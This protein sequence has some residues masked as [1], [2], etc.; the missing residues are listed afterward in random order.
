[1]DLVLELSTQDHQIFLNLYKADYITNLNELSTLIKAFQA[2]KTAIDR[3]GDILRVE[4]ERMN[5]V[6]ELTQK[7]D[8]TDLE[9]GSLSPRG[10]A[11]KLKA[12][13]GEFSQKIVHHSDLNK[14]A[15]KH[16]ECINQGK[17]KVKNIVGYQD[18]LLRAHTQMKDNQCK[19]M[20]RIVDGNMSSLGDLSMAEMARNQQP[21]GFSE[22]RYPVIRDESQILNQPVRSEAIP[23][24]EPPKQT[25]L[26]KSSEARL[27]EEEEAALWDFELKFDPEEAYMID[28]SK[29]LHSL[30]KYK[31]NSNVSQSVRFDMNAILIYTS[32]ADMLTWSWMQQVMNKYVG[33]FNGNALRGEQ[34][35]V[36]FR[37]FSYRGKKIIE[38]HL[39]NCG[40]YDHTQ[41]TSRVLLGLYADHQILCE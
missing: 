38:T 16:I 35:V 11:Q 13:F 18:F 33:C 7:V 9:F 10:R 3:M 30:L 39:E 20:M 32:I 17:V 29:R 5:L 28:T 36:D 21:Q 22:E 26:V 14:R 23:V 41:N 25:I 24:Y 40:R 37:D 12:L 34:N 19:I 31:L 2:M 4:K 15:C 8:V 27:S 1:M 6:K